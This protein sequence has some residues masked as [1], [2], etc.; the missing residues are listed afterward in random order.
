MGRGYKAYELA[1][2]EQ[3][4][5]MGISDDMIDRMADELKS[6]GPYVIDFDTFLGACVKCGIDPNC[7][8]Q[9]DLDRLV[10]RLN[11]RG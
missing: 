8:E 6:C 3:A 10:D 4:G 5:Y 9:K 1:A 2:M 11:E 7:F